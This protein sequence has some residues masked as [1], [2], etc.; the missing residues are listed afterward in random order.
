M[1][2]ILGAMMDDPWPEAMLA[3]PWPLRLARTFGEQALFDRRIQ[4]GAHGSIIQD[5]DV[6]Y[7]LSIPRVRDRLLTI[8]YVHGVSPRF[9]GA[10][11]VFR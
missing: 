4:I 2:D 9:G 11:A 3:G 10:M 5:R 8:D 6:V 7:V 1:W